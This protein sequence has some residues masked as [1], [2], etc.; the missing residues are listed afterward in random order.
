MP[1]PL[2]I[3]YLHSHDTGR[4]IQPYGYGIATPNLAT[5]A[6]QGVLFRRA[7]CVGPTCSP[8]RAGLLT[9][10][11]AHCA[12]MLGLAHR[13]WQLTDFSQHIVHPLRAAGYRTTLVGIQHVA[14][15][16]EMIGYD[17]VLPTPNSRAQ[18]VAPAAEAFLQ[19]GPKQPF[20][21][22]VGFFETHRTFPA[23]RRAEDAHYVMPPA[24]L[25][26]TPQTRLDTAAF[27]AS[28]RDL[29]TGIGQI[30][31]ALDRTGLARNT[32]VLYTTDHG[33]AFPDQKCNL[34]DHGIGVSLIL[35]GPGPFNSGGPTGGVI[36]AMVSHV[37]VFPTVFE[38]AGLPRPAW[39]QGRSMMPL[40][41]GQSPSI[42][43]EL[44]AEVTYHAAFEP[45]RA[46]RTERYKYI[47][48]FGDRRKPVLP[49]CD[50]GPSKTLWMEHAWKDRP[51]DS[52]Q[53]F[54]LVY[55]PQER[56][57]LLG[58]SYCPNDTLEEMR[59]RLDRWMK[60]TDDPL[61]RDPLPIPRP[62]KVN[63]PDEIDPHDNPRIVQP[64][65]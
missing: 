17:A 65:V 19:A 48:R 14:P 18:N 34:T 60:E 56:D 7:F 3:V 58:R 36:D 12:G 26:D 24:P 11:W 63:D 61:L 23:P 44:F 15:K 21:L 30:L 35:R 9:G 55:D 6:G 47:R 52:E 64:T 46:V 38:A 40:L 57:N 39:F 45:M 59:G 25:P 29:D 49:N 62:I 22:D 42:R 8:S 33:P 16:S 2:N 41:R 32:L 1:E 28:A 53:L 43:E 13:G 20:F 31:Q 10:Q 50:G 27:A 4:F 37:D 54:D 5:L 51:I